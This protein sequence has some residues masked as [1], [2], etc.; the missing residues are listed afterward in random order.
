MKKKQLLGASLEEVLLPIN[1]AYYDRLHDK[2]M[3]RI[4]E[5]EMETPARPVAKVFEKSSRL[6][7]DHWRGWLYSRE[8]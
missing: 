3:A 8:S 1:P 7:R 2:I 6:L 4:E 5:T